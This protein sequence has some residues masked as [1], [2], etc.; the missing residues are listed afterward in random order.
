MK[1]RLILMTKDINEPSLE[2]L[3]QTVVFKV[4]ILLLNYK[5]IHL[6]FGNIEL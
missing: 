5:N 1:T 6:K 3:F 2:F 4:F